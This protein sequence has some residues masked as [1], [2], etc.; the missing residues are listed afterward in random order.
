M[1]IEEI[2]TQ[3]LEAA[4]LLKEATADL[5]HLSVEN[6]APPPA[7]TAFQGMVRKHLKDNN[8][9]GSDQPWDWIKRTYPNAVSRIHT[10]F[11]ATLDLA[12]KAV[13]PG[14]KYWDCIDA[15]KALREPTP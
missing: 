12:R 7:E 2:Q 10:T 3:L 9:S 15:I 8:Y 1:N 14:N 11:N 5:I 6:K 13:V 4:D